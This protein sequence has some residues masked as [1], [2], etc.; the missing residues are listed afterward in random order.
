MV[1]PNESPDRKQEG[2]LPDP[3]RT[4]KGYR[5]WEETDL[6]VFS[7]IVDNIENDIIADFALHQTSKALWDNLAITFESKTN[8][9]LVYD[10]EDKIISIR[11]GNLDLETYYRRIHGLWV[12]IDRSQ[13]QPITCCD[14][15]IE[16]YRQ[17][18]SEKRL[19]KFLTGLSQEYDHIRREIL[20]QQPYPSVE[21][22]YG[23]VKKEAA[24]LKIMPPASAPPTGD[25]TGVG[26]ADASS[27]EIG[28]GFEA[29]RDRPNNRGSQQRPP[30][31]GTTYQT[32]EGKPDKSKLWCSHSHCGK[33]KHTRET[34]FLRVGYPEWWDEKQKA[35]AQGKLAAVGI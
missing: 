15:G 3:R 28:Y 32:A 31:A 14:K 20:K 21:E 16:Q 30:P 8:P 10:L 34:C 5:D 22:A 17:H 6:T 11:Q 33:N 23:W 27:G 24:R 2:I 7:W 9:Y 19:I 18:A 29:Q 1:S 26:S 35:R 4:S 13:K 12:N 25:S